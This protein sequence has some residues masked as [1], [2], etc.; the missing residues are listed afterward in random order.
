ML[1]SAAAGGKESYKCCL[2]FGCKSLM[3]KRGDDDDDASVSIEFSHMSEA[4]LV[5]MPPSPTSSTAQHITTLA[6]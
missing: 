3:E 1:A 4:V 5:I 2:G 6:P